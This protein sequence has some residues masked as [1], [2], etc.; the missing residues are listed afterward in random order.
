MERQMH[1]YI[2]YSQIYI[3]MDRYI[4]RWTDRYKDGQI[5]IKMDREIYRYT[6]R[7]IEYRYIID[8]NIDRQI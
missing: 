8:I 6:N 5:D 4:Y 1:R 7:Y 2:L 3:Q